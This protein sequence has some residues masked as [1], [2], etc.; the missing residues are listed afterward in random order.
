MSEINDDYLVHVCPECG[1]I[2]GTNDLD[3]GD[4]PQCGFAD[5][6]E[7]SDPVG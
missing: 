5:L 2:G 7:E 6:I 4:C 1:W 3:Q